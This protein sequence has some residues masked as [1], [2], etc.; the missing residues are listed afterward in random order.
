MAEDRTDRIQI[1]VGNP[2]VPL[3]YG[4]GFTIGV[5]TSGDL[6]MVLEANGRPVAV[7]NL[8]LSVAKTMAI[9]LAGVVSQA[10]E[11]LGSEILTTHE[12]EKILVQKAEN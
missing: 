1:A 6:V 3:I 11:K 10:E 9:A 5:P 2:S 4:N 7:L 12:L 8:T